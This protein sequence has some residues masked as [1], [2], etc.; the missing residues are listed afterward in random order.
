[1]LWCPD[2]KPW[3]FHIRFGRNDLPGMLL[4]AS[5]FSASATNDDQ[6]AGRT[7]GSDG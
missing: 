4:E 3:V 6:I 2:R 7:P 5:I 1:V